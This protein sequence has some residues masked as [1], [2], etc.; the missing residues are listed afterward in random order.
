MPES[1]YISGAGPTAHPT[2]SLRRT[3]DEERGLVPVLSFHRGY[4]PVPSQIGCAGLF[5]DCQVRVRIEGMQ[6]KQQAL[7]WLLNVVII[8]GFTSLV[9]LCY[10]LKQ[11]NKKLTLE[12]AEGQVRDERTKITM[13]RSTL[14]ES[15][16]QD[17]DPKA[18]SAAHQDIRH[19]VA[20]RSRHWSASAR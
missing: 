2:N 16:E 9:V 4:R 1:D 7:Q 20:Q 17:T 3:S 13:A 6:L 8:T 10:V 14:P 19:F 5:L 12:L 15:A 18:S 11:D